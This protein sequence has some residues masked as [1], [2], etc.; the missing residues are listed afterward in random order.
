MNPLPSSKEDQPL[1]RFMIEDRNQPEVMIVDDERN[2]RRVLSMAFVNEYRVF[3]ARNAKAALDTLRRR[4]MDVVLT[5]ILLPDADGITLLQEMKRIDPALEIIMVTAVKDV[6]TAVRAIKSGAYEYLLKPFMVDEVRH[7]L[8]RALEKHRLSREVASL[9]RELGGYRPFENMLG[10]NPKMREVFHMITAVACSDGAV[11]VQGESGTGKELVARAVHNRSRR[12]KK[13]FMVINCGAVP[14]S[15]MER[16]LFG[17]N[18]GAF[19]HATST[20]PGKLEMAEGGTV[21]LDDIDSMDTGMQ[22]KLLR[23]IQHKEFERLGGNRLIRADIRFVAASNKDLQELIREG[24]FREDLYFRLNVFPIVLPPLRE[25]REDIPMLLNHFLEACRRNGN[26]VPERF[27]ER[28]L[29]TLV[30]HDWP[31]NIRELENLVLRICTV[32][33]AREIRVH[34]L[35]NDLAPRDARGSLTLREAVRDFERKYIGDTLE[36]V[37]GS[38]Q[39]AAALLGIHRN[40]LRGKMDRLGM[41]DQN[42]PPAWNQW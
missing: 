38:R 14:S 21:F 11:L 30:Q 22:A 3:T 32:S 13:P 1:R 35:P 40:T 10:R 28:A 20:L 7:V 41:I 31:G 37:Q 36:R 25:R 9:R 27:S 18:R 15:L 8:D 24:R 6:Q 4:S 34:H 29:E 16:E 19:T 39:E 12:R 42:R 23:A 17:H 33:R 2:V 26:G 5:D